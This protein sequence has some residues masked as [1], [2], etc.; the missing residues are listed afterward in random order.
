MISDVE[1]KRVAKDEVSV[2]LTYDEALVLS[3]LLD[4][5]YQ[6]GWEGVATGDLA[7]IR[8]LD[9]LCASFEPVIDEVFADDY[10]EIVEAARRRISPLSKP[11]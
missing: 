8:V 3:D 10:G 6:A 7:E 5:W 1:T 9:G 2:R 11:D 4:R